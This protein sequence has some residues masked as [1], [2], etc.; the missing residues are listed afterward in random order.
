MTLKELRKT[1]GLTQKDA[2]DIT[3]TSLR[4]FASYETDEDKA[5]QLKLQRIKEILEE[6]ADNDTN[7][8]K[9]KVLLI[10]GGTGSF[11]NA[12]L[13]RFLKTDIG[14]IRIF[15]RDEKKQ[16]DMRH[17]YQ[18]KYPECFQKIKWGIIRLWNQKWRYGKT[19]KESEWNQIPFCPE[20][21]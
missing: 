10:T 21:Q 5:D 12:V 2:A 17:E 20:Q 11:G 7:I 15:S 19:W 1:C 4:S 13:N 6:Y 14:E 9:G 8:L 16:D 3:R 18:A